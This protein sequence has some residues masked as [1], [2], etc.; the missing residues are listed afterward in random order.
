ML[1]N[2]LELYEYDASSSNWELYGTVYGHQ[3]QRSNWEWLVS[4][5]RPVQWYIGQVRSRKK[6]DICEENVFSY[7]LPLK[8]IKKTFIAHAFAC[9]ILQLN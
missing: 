5:V 2:I 1:E 7:Q 6:L 8:V 9:H 4:H 3:S